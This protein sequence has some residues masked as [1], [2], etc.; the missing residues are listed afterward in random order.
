MA[1]E[2]LSADVGLC[3]APGSG[4]FVLSVLVKFTAEPSLGARGR[5][6]MGDCTEILDNRG[7]S[8][9]GRTVALGTL[10]RRDVSPGDGAS[11][12][13]CS[14]PFA[15]GK[16]S[17]RR[18]S[19]GSACGDVSVRGEFID[20]RGSASD[21]TLVIGGRPAST[22]DRTSWCLETRARA[23]IPRKL[24]L[25]GGAGV[26]C[27]RAASGIARDPVPELALVPGPE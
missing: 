4:V 26:L 15:G 11:D 20:D 9:V 10:D 23:P 6:L 24:V 27:P 16:A 22:D 17:L 25:S 21:N 18:R 3:P 8:F 7:T 2:V 1:A 5:S 12:A 13:R 14:W 19:T